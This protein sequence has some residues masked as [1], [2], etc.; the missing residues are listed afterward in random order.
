MIRIPQNAV[1]AVAYAMAVKDIRYYLNGMLVEHN[2]IETRLVCTDGYRLHA[3]IVNHK[4]GELLPAVVS[5]IVPD[6]MVKAMCKEKP[7]YRK[8]AVAFDIAVE[9]ANLSITMPDG[10]ETHCKPIDGTFSDYRRA[11]PAEF[12]GECAQY[13]PSYTADAE[14]GAVA[15][16]CRYPCFCHN[17]DSAGGIALDGFVAVVMPRRADA[18]LDA[19]DAAFRAAMAVAQPEEIAA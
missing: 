11:I 7:A 14:A 12:S 5:F 13:N 10:T 19:P 6:T 3:C 17:G 4:D 9:G 15:W 8:Q 1:R 2:G 18:T 16:G